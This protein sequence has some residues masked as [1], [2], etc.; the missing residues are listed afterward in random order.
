[1]RVSL[2]PDLNICRVVDGRRV[3]YEK[4]EDDDD[5]EDEEDEASGSEEAPVALTPEE[6]WRA[7]DQG[8]FTLQVFQPQQN[9]IQLR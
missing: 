8:G 5:D 9:C 7:H 4:D 1:M 2:A 6:V 3:E